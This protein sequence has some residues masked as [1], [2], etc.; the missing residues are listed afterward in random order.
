MPLAVTASTLVRA[1][2]LDSAPGLV[3]DV[4]IY[5]LTTPQMDSAPGLVVDVCIY[6]LNPPQM[7]SASYG[8]I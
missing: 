3:V 4:C 7:D 2:E 8:D 1:A 5:P 6:Q